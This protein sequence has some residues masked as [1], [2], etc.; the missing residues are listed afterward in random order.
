M[1][2][3][4]NKMNQDLGKLTVENVGIVTHVIRMMTR[5]MNFQSPRIDKGI[6]IL[7]VEEHL[8]VQIVLANGRPII[9]QGY[10][11]LIYR[12]NAGRLR[13]RDHKTGAN[14]SSWHSASLDL[15]SQLLFYAL[16]YWMKTGDVPDLVE[17]SFA[18]TA[19][20]KNKKVDYDQLFK[21]LKKSI[22]FEALQQFRLHLRHLLSRMYNGENKLHRF[23]KDCVSCTYKPLCELELNG[24]STRATIQSGYVRTNRDYSVRPGERQAEIGTG[25]SEVDTGADQDFTIS[26]DD[27]L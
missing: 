20:Y 10:V 4:Q 21:F 7:G 6:R 1:A 22:T 9:L 17:I 12:D 8:E 23:S 24:L 26:F 27:V 2:A 3:M 18:S 11:D 5:F 15:D 19:E 16:V 25:L 14:P 13:I